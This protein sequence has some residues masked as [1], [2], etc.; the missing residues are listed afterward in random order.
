M[1]KTIYY[2][3]FI[4]L[5]ACSCDEKKQD[6]IEANDYNFNL[7]HVPFDELHYDWEN[8][9]NYHDLDPVDS[10]GIVLFEYDDEYYYQPVTIA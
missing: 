2:L 7:N 1:K 4:L 6:V 3:S 10:L 9:Y 8:V 5:F